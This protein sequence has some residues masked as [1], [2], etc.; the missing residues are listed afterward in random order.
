ME[1]VLSLVE[2]IAGNELKYMGLRSVVSTFYPSGTDLVTNL[3]IAGHNLAS[4][5]VS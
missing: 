1:G 2:E 3:L 4:G 5:G